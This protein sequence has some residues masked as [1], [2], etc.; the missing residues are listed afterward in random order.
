MNN[1]RKARHGILPQKK[2]FKGTMR[3]FV[4][5][6]AEVSKENN[7]IYLFENGP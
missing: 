2:R 4:N 1:D 7:F 5:R 3:I 6:I